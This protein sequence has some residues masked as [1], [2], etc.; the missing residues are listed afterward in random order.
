[1]YKPLADVPLKIGDINEISRIWGVYFTLGKLKIKQRNIR[2]EATEMCNAWNHPI[3]C[4][5]G[6]GG[7]GHLGGGGST[8]NTSYVPKIWNTYDSYV[9]P[10]A[11]CPVCGAD[12][13]FYRSPDGGAVFFDE[14]GPPWPKHPCTNDTR[15]T[16][17]P[18]PRN[19][20][21]SP[22]A[23]IY[24]WQRNG[25]N[26]LFLS[27]VIDRDHQVLMLTCI[28][29]GREL[30]LYIKRVVNHHAKQN[31][32][33]VSN[34]VFAKTIDEDTYNLSIMSESLLIFDIFAYRS[35]HALRDTLIKNRTY[36]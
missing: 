24:L 19:T 20:N 8:W 11:R 9:N 26:P 5:C 21:T 35:L 27:E 33:K 1:V 16:Y 12:V 10:N 4:T 2:S 28:Y 17:N 3:D 31:P 18:I 6:F 15:T 22:R 29:L 34:I 25:W 23:P 7:E 13:F 14:L 30:I 36:A 32:I